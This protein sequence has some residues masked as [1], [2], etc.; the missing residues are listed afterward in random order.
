MFYILEPM[1]RPLRKVTAAIFP[2]PRYPR[3]M[4]ESPW[5][6]LILKSLK[7]YFATGISG[8]KIVTVDSLAALKL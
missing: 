8:K 2:T 5:N 4:G 1:A 7:R 6:F 3:E